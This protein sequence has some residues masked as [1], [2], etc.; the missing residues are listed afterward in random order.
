MRYILLAVFTFLVLQGCSSKEE[1]VKS[2][3][4]HDTQKANEAFK[5]LDQETKK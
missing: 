1:I 2:Q 5:E 4:V 3:Y